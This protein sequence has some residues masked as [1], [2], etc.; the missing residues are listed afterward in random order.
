MPP[1]MP[2]QITGSA[3]PSCA[4]CTPTMHS[5]RTQTELPRASPGNGSTGLDLLDA[6]ITGCE[7]RCREPPQG[8]RVHHKIDHRGDNHA[9][10]YRAGKASES[11]LSA[12]ERK[13]AW[14][15]R[16]AKPSLSPP[17][18]HSVARPCT[19]AQAFSHRAGS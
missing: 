14:P 12:I 2:S 9:V 5:R 7:G 17:S 8:V 16:P 11:M 18:F 1:T 4:L 10:H 6:G 3:L 19:S 13:A 15:P